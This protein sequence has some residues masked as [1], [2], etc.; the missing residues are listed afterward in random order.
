MSS[1]NPAAASGKK[2]K[3]KL[4]QGMGGNVPHFFSHQ[5]GAI[6]DWDAVEAQ[7]MVERGM[8]SYIEEPKPAASK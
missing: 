6:L 1:S 2:V 8:A 3:I 5:P 7:R 4:L